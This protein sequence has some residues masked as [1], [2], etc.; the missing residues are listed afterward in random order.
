[1]KSTLF[2]YG[3]YKAIEHELVKRYRD[4]CKGFGHCDANGKVTLG[5][6][7]HFLKTAVRGDAGHE[8]V[9]KQT[10]KPVPDQKLVKRLDEFSQA[11]RNTAAHPT[12]FP[13][14]R[15][16]KMRKALFPN[17]LLRDIADALL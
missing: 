5:N 12:E 6:E 16:D 15:L 4:A 7:V 3:S 14:E 1:M 13:L 17:R 11:F 2:L 8:R 10:G 9:L